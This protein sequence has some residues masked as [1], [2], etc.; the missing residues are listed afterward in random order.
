MWFVCFLRC[1][2][3]IVW[4]ANEFISVFLEIGLWYC[5][6]CWSHGLSFR[7]FLGFQKPDIYK[8]G[9]RVKCNIF[10]EKRCC[11][12]CSGNILIEYLEALWS[13]PLT[14]TYTQSLIQAWSFVLMDIAYSVRYLYLTQWSYIRFFLVC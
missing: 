4:K 14:W 10:P 13:K 6:K 12:F 11:L 7:H 2:F 9:G 1:C 8:T 5:V 3:C